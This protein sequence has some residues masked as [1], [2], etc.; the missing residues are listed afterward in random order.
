MNPLK[1][2][3]RL[4]LIAFIFAGAKPLKAAPKGAE[5]LLFREKKNALQTTP[6]VSASSLAA[7]STAEEQIDTFAVTL[8][9]TSEDSMLLVEEVIRSTENTVGVKLVASQNGEWQFR[10][11]GYFS[12]IETLRDRIEQVIQRVCQI[13]LPAA[14]I[15]DPGK[16]PFSGATFAIKEGT[17]EVSLVEP[18]T[19]ANLGTSSPVGAYERDLSSLGSTRRAR[20]FVQGQIIQER[21]PSN[22]KN[23]QTAKFEAVTEKAVNIAPSF[24]SAT[25]VTKSE[26]DDEPVGAAAVM[27]ILSIA[28]A[29]VL[30]SGYV[31]WIL[32]TRKRSRRHVARPPALQPDAV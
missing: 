8:L 28:G 24:S 31:V 17:L 1:H 27:I 29:I 7:T 25:I 14:G 9:A 21:A 15:A 12:N 16:L 13:G 4:V 20:G 11:R 30:A 2:I 23:L 6:I 3:F 10:V 5:L 19:S 18:T 22:P 32:V 26:Q